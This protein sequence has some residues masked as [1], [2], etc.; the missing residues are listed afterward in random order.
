MID[1][2]HGPDCLETSRTFKVTTKSHTNAAGDIEYA[3]SLHDNSIYPLDHQDGCFGLTVNAT[4]PFQQNKHVRIT[5]D[6]DDASQVVDITK[7]SLYKGDELVEDIWSGE[8]GFQKLFVVKDQLIVPNADTNADYKYKLVTT[9]K[10]E[11]KT[12]TFNSNAFKIE[13]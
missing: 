8:E 9:S 4:G 10:V 1:G 5:A 7:V 2:Q 13:N 12:C 6:R 3:E 11:G